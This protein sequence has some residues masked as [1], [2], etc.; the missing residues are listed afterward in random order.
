MPI[1]NTT[2][3]P[4]FKS[5]NEK[6]LLVFMS[7]HK[8]WEGLYD[9]VDIGFIRNLFDHCLVTD[10]PD[11]LMTTIIPANI[12]QTKL[13]EL[14][15]KQ[16]KLKEFLL[17]YGVEIQ[18]LK[19]RDRTI[20]GFISGVNEIQQL[21]KGYNRR[22]IWAKNYF[23]G[24]M[25]VLLKRRDPGIH[26][27]FELSGL[28][29]EEELYYSYSNIFIRVANFLVLKFFGRANI[30][31]ADSVSVVSRRFKEY[32]I[33]KYHLRSQKVEVLPC[34]YD[35]QQFYVNQRL[36]EQFRKK[37]QIEDKQ[38]VILYS[39]MLQKWQQPDM[40]FSFLKHIQTLDKDHKFR[41]MMATFDQAKARSLATKYGIQEL[42]IDSGNVEVLNGIYNAANIGVAFR[43]ADM[44]SYV[45]SPVKIPEYLATGN[46]LI[47]LEHIGDYGKDL[48]GKDYVLIKKNQIDL[49]E[50]SIDEIDHLTKP[51]AEDLREIFEKY[52]IKSNLEIIKRIINEN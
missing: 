41:F 35:H 9:T 14:A 46:S 50:T 18:F 33:K 5:N 24:F 10:K 27:H 49:L 43:S 45:S 22:F 40:F 51:T 17:N 23:N 48:M 26:L 3:T 28:V 44:V 11:V 47:L 7:S 15:E 12:A 36:R 37:Y 25:G 2:G 38:K 6:H 32:I 34:F 52:S 29:P 30:K 19:I 8:F 13:Y 31:T 20:F 39:G 21:A 1:S 42:I 16:G 4:S